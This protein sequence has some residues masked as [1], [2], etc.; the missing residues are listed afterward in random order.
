MKVILKF[1]E[2]LQ[3]LKSLIKLEKLFHYQFKIEKE[4]FYKLKIKFYFVT[5]NE[6]YIICYGNKKQLN[7]LIDYDIEYIDQFKLFINKV[8]LKRLVIIMTFLLII[9]VFS[10]SSYFIREIRFKDNNYYDSRV[11]NYVF[12]RLN[13]SMFLYTLDGDINEISRNLRAAFPNYAYIGLEKKGSVLE[14]DIEKIDILEKDNKVKNNLPI[15][16]NYNAVIYSISCKNGVVLVNLNQSVKKGDL[17]I[18]PNNEKGYCDGIILGALSE[19]EKIIVKK[20]VID[21]GLT[22]KFDK[23][24][25]IK[26]GKN[27][28]MKFK[29][30]YLEQDIKLDKMF[31]LFNVLEVY[32]VY[33]YEKDFYK[34]VYDYET[35]YNYAVSVFYK[36][37][38]LYRKSNLEKINEIK[39]LNFEETKDEFVFYFLVNKVKS[40]GI[41]SYNN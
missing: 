28:L 22:G 12:N 34:F 9:F 38:E 18:N 10:S 27:Y 35:A 24:F 1:M 20:E 14:I 31:N 4:L 29:D 30:F 33:Y 26:V 37:L 17:L 41:Y 5:S 40:I 6:N 8:F 36:N 21:F 39:L 16:S 15:I 25:A 7:K 11:Y 2:K 32:R 23:K 19:Y 13:K 3:K